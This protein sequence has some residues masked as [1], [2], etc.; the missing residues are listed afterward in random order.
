MLYTMRLGAPAP[1]QSGLR[2]SSCEAI[3]R[4]SAFDRAIHLEKPP[5]GTYEWPKAF[6]G[7][8]KNGLAC[9]QN[10]AEN[11][12]AFPVAAAEIWHALFTY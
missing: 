6:C 5:H 10:D 9:K 12:C 7:H 11:N 8:K 1:L 4:A 3:T 2:R